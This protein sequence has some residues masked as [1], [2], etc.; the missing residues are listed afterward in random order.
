[1]TN[2]KIMKTIKTIE[3]DLYMQSVIDTKT[4]EDYNGFVKEKEDLL[5]KFE[6]ILTNLDDIEIREIKE[7]LD[8]AKN[9]MVFEDIKI[10]V[11]TI[12]RELKIG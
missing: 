2:I 4:V 9:Y 8:I 10:I 12:K 3:T 6:Y 1:M 11:N 7:V 5:R